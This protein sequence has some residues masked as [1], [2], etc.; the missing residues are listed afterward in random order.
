MKALTRP[1][2][3][4]IVV[5]VFGIACVVGAR[6]LL[7]D[8][9]PAEVS[10]ATRANVDRAE[11]ASASK[12]QA[13]TKHPS[14]I[15]DAPPPWAAASAA[16][17][18]AALPGDAAGT[19]AATASAGAMLQGLGAKSA[20]NETQIR[21]ALDNIESLRTSGADT[22]GVNLEALQ[23]NLEIALE[24]NQIGTEI[25]Q[26]VTRESGGKRTALMREK[27]ARLQQLQDGL[28]Y[29][30]QQPRQAPAPPPSQGPGEQ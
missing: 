2:R 14:A 22:H 6:W 1:V 24:M 7:K 23:N 9:A 13:V 12:A 5:I 11:T 18:A 21:K 8:A 30:I 26:L 20:E 3:L 28:R 19:A 29:D 17:R 4:A 25:Q 16:P 10:P 15:D 27:L